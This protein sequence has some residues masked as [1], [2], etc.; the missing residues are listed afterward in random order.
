MFDVFVVL[1]LPSASF[2]CVGSE[3]QS[4]YFRDPPGPRVHDPT[5]LGSSLGVHYFH[6]VI[7]LR[8]TVRNDFF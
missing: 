2:V 4:V 5:F 1:L 8:V 6:N 3:A 7:H